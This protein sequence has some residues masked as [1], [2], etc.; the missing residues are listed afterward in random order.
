MFLY[1]GFS[2][3]KSVKKLQISKL[4]DLNPLCLYIFILALHCLMFSFHV[5]SFIQTLIIFSFYIFILILVPLSDDMPC[6]F[7]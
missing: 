1:G 5:Y 6:L 3:F 4:F 7:D 2:L